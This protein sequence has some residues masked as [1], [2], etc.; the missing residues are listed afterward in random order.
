MGH[1]KTPRLQLSAA[2]GATLQAHP[3]P[4]TESGHSSRQCG[5]CTPNV[6]SA[7][8]PLTRAVPGTCELLTLNST[9][10]DTK[11]FIMPALYIR[12][13]H[14]PQPFV[15]Q[16]GPCSPLKPQMVWGAT[17]HVPDPL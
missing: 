5:H 15:P 10:H 14:V 17:A 3:T 11:G 12:L 2:A 1:T 9:T 13:A 16:T 6:C 4:A 8:S 7:P